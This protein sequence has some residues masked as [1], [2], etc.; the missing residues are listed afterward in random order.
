[1]TPTP[2]LGWINL[3]E[4]L[5]DL[6]E[7]FYLL[8]YRF[9][10]KGCNSGTARWKRCRGQGMGKGHGASTPS[11]SVPLSW[12]LHVFTNSETL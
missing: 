5:T 3:L 4:W 7:T 8:D 12:H 2:S 11:P 1:M 6:R 9:I 10:I